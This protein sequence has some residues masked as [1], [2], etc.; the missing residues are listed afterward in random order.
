MSDKDAYLK[1]MEDAV[2]K[3]NAAMTKL[4]QENAQL[5]NQ[6]AI[7]EAKVASLEKI[8]SKEYANPSFLVVKPNSP[9]TKAVKRGS[10]S[11]NS[12]VPVKKT[13]V[14]NPKKLSLTAPTSLISKSK[15]G[16]K[17]KQ[18]TP[19][20]SSSTIP[21]ISIPNLSASK[22]N[23]VEKG[24]DDEMD[25]ALEEMFD[26]ISSDSSSDEG[27][28]S[29]DESGGGG[30]D[31]VQNEVRGLPRPA[32]VQTSQPSTKP[33]NSIPTDQTCNSTNPPPYIVLCDPQS[34]KEPSVPK[35]DQTKSCRGWSKIK[36]PKNKK[37]ATSN[38]QSV[39]NQL[40][41]DTVH[42]V[43]RALLTSPP[44][45]AASAVFHLIET[46]AMANS[47]LWE[48]FIT[49]D[50][51]ESMG[52][53]REFVNLI[54]LLL[55]SFISENRGKRGLLCYQELM[56][57]LQQHALSV[58]R[59]HG[60]ARSP[61]N[62]VRAYMLGKE[63]HNDDTTSESEP[64]VSAG[65]MKEKH[66]S[67]TEEE[68]DD[69]SEAQGNGG[70]S[71]GQLAPSGAADENATVSPVDRGESQSSGDVVLGVSDHIDD[72]VGALKDLMSDREHGSDSDSDSD[73]DS[74][75]GGED[76]EGEDAF[77]HNRED[78]T[79][80]SGDEGEGKNSVMDASSDVK[81]TPKLTQA[82]R[83]LI[84]CVASAIAVQAALN[85]VRRFI[86]HRLLNS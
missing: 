11:T 68:D 47:V 12:D 73:A 15:P 77:P 19:T 82:V 21:P 52:L 36:V 20:I 79:G 2:I 81:T 39:A 51:V 66:L 49:R 48:A 67:E 46:F 50:N 62:N 22:T 58:R 24:N 30:H 6:V 13:R 28:G 33:G 26:D 5:L 40:T 41:L 83:Q 10:D 27:S 86:Y 23:I 1:R 3:A 55:G 54:E 64:S 17:P 43:A 53:F 76:D 60:T 72:D 75:F 14:E 31:G 63:V 74:V 9:N 85:M 84:S 38:M 29:D 18:S 32:M 34:K 8:R 44:N 37:G 57:T 78:G 4:R 35:S 45:V 59:L 65:N 69:S 16:P 7:L 42:S 25:R 71:A 61:L 56:F 70:T 80:E